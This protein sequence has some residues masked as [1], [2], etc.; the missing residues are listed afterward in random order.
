MAQVVPAARRKIL[1]AKSERNPMN[2]AAASALL[3]PQ[4]PAPSRSIPS[5]RRMPDSPSDDNDSRTAAV[6]PR[7]QTNGSRQSSRQSSH[8]SNPNPRKRQRRSRSADVRNVRDFV[9]QGATFSAA[10]LGVD[11]DATSSSGSDSDDGSS[12]GG[13][14]QQTESAPAPP[15]SW[16]KG[17][18]SAIRTSL[19]SRG[20]PEESKPT[21]QFD[22]VNDQFWRSRSESVSSHG[23]PETEASKPGQL[24]GIEEGEVN[25]EED[26]DESSQ[27][28]L[29][30]DSDDSESL[31]S[32]ADDSILLNIGSRNGQSLGQD[33]DGLITPDGDDDYDPEAL[34]VSNGTSINGQPAANQSKE[35]A[36]LRFS[37]KYP[38]PP[39][40]LADLDREDM[41]IQ[42]KYRFYD[43]DINAIDLQLPIACTECLLEGHLAEVCPS[44]E[45]I[46][47]GAWNQHQSS[48]CPTWRRCQRCRARGHSDDNCPS[49]LKGSPSEFPCELC[50]S[51][52]HIEEDCD[53]MW[54]LTTRPEPSSSE[55]V[56]VSLS[57]AHCT[58]N[59][60]LIG[61]CPSLSSSRTLL[62][63]SWTVRGID[64][65]MITNINS[66]VNHRRNNNNNSNNN[67]NNNNNRGG[68]KIRGRADHRPPSS[69]SDDMMVHRRPPVHRGG[70]SGGSN[71]RGNIRIGSGIGRGNKNISSNGYRDRSD[72]GPSSRQRSMS[73]NPRPRGGGRGGKDSW[74]GGG[75]RGKSSGSGGSRPPSR[76]GNPG[77]G[78]GRG[79]KRGGGG[80]DAYRPLPSAAKKAWDKYRL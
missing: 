10:G 9:P 48:F 47:C 43:R 36:L 54:K 13:D 7:A 30:G 79:G 22:T 11:V 44:R 68:L 14:A 26:S 76:G 31:G 17:S 75:G 5:P 57:C 45:C 63:S 67:N 58:S 38:T 80:G 52:T 70:G 16:N 18:K 37:K 21:S 59:R 46:H 2:L 28:Q 65:H 69:D 19:R 33:Q 8:D 78:G 3:T 40:T 53:L 74:Q 56:L 25:E 29:S 71:N 6:G 60:H 1:S 35:D 77:R 42:A 50:G 23:D 61:D 55:P 62:S 32:E 72:F 4:Q 15:A 51:S 41:D 34:P 39:S 12:E 24:D 73:P 20:K 49:A 27:M 64:P 66:V